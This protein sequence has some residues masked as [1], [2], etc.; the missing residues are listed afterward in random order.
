MKTRNRAGREGRDR[1]T[2]TTAG[3]GQG[4]GMKTRNMAEGRDGRE[5]PED[6]EGTGRDREGTCAETFSFLLCAP[7]TSVY[8]EPSS[9]T[10][11]HISASLP[12]CS[13][14]PSF[15]IALSLSL[16]LSLSSVPLSFISFNALLSFASRLCSLCPK[17]FYAHTTRPSQPPSFFLSP[18]TPL[19]YNALPTPL[20]VLG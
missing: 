4:R 9:F 5:G 11:A 14:Q 1:K 6:R 18:T 8:S 20:P 10:M 13:Q 2:G 15:S 19:P 7:Q 12:K 17:D 16:S 3:G